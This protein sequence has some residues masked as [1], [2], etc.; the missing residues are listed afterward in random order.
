MTSETLITS[1]FV[2]NRYEYTF[3]HLRDV[4]TMCGKRINFILHGKLKRLLKPLLQL[5]DATD[6]PCGAHYSQNEKER[7]LTPA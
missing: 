3:K 5:C 4:Q 2:N 7:V 1:K 6:S